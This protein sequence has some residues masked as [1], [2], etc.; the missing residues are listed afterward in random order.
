[1]RLHLSRRRNSRTNVSRS[2]ILIAKGPGDR[3]PCMERETSRC[4]S[5]RWKKERKRERQHPTQIGSYRCLP[6]QRDTREVGAKCCGR[7]SPALPKNH[8]TEPSRRFLN[9]LSRLSRVEL[10][11]ES[12]SELYTASLEEHADILVWTGA[13]VKQLHIRLADEATRKTDAP[14]DERAGE[15][16]G[17]LF[18]R[19][20]PERPSFR[21][22]RPPMVPTGGFELIAG[23]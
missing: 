21:R 22:D 8:V 2:F 10:H 1:M 11:N 17:H 14:H 23:K 18:S 4:W 16:A 3:M 13:T 6:D 7:T 19:E 5:E 20:N 12:A 9:G 15:R